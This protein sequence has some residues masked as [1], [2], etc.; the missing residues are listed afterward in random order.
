MQV[1]STTHEE[2]NRIT[3]C[4]NPP[5]RDTQTRAD[6]DEASASAAAVSQRFER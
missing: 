2:W 6:T 4:L 3:V 1:A 5:R